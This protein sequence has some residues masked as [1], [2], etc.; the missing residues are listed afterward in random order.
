MSCIGSL[1]NRC[2]PAALCLLACLGWNAAAVGDDVADRQAAYLNS[3]YDSF[4]NHA[5]LGVTAEVTV[6][7]A[8]ATFALNKPA[9]DINAMNAALHTY[10]DGKEDYWNGKT[11]DRPR[12]TA[13]GAPRRWLRWRPIPTSRST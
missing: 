3:Y 13:T 9:A 1:V 4:R 12:S 11:G 5:N 6:N 7:M 10:L 8:Y 2:L